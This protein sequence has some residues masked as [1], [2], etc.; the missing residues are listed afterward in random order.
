MKIT[1]RLLVLA[2]IFFFFCSAALAEELKLGDRADDFNLQDS[3]GEQYS[4]NSQE[5]QGKVLSIFYVDPDEADMNEH[6]S[7][8]LKKAADKGVLDRTYYKGFA[9][10]N[11]KAT[12][13]PNF[14]VKA[15]VKSKK[16]KYQTVILLD[17]D[18]TILNLWGLEN[19]SSNLVVL[20]K[21][22]ICRYVYKGK[23]PES[24]IPAIIQIIKE[25]E[26]K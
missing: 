26:S 16:K 15:I 22:R 21:N 13:K 23:I 18:F 19:D 25:Y 8:A 17:Y 3:E 1:Y 5:F 14:L 20:D 24:E 2:S 9:I 7:E 10:T 12:W 11:L 4:L 6:V